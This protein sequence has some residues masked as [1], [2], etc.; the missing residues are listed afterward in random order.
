ELTS[1]RFLVGFSNQTNIVVEDFKR[2]TGY[3]YYTIEPLDAFFIT[4]G[5][6]YDSVEYPENFRAPPISPGTQ[7]E[8]LLGPKAA[9][10]YSPSKW[11]TLRGIYARSLGGVS[12]D[13]SYRLEPT[14]LAG[15]VQTFR[16]IIPE[17]VVG[18]VSAPTFDTY[19]TAL[20]FKF[21]TGTYIGVYAGVLSADVSQTIGVFDYKFPNV[22]PS[23]TGEDF[24]FEER[25]IGITVNQLLGNRWSCGAAYRFTSSRLTTLLP[26]I[27]ISALTNANDTAQSDLHQFGA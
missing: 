2:A 5:L 26:D 25:S 16:S 19:G 18:S 27:P 11:V 23:S 7:S 17:S 6:S 20:D 3:A 12:L 8:D 22:I 14:Q 10:V 1:T 15:F 24:D 4:G 13:Q 9:L 21:D